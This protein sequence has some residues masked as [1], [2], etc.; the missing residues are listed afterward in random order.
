MELLMSIALVIV[1][2]LF[3][4]WSA[5]RFISAATTVAVHANV[6]PLIVGMVIVGFGTSAP[7][8][9]VSLLATVSNSEGIAFGNVFGSN[10]TNILLGLGL[11]A[12]ITPLRVSRNILRYQLPLLCFVTVVALLFFWNLHFSRMEAMIFLLLFI[13]SMSL[14]AYLESKEPQKEHV[15]VA[16]LR[17]GTI[18]WLILSFI[19]LITSSQFL[20]YGAR[21]IA[22]Y[23]GV[24]ELIIG[25]TV[26]AVGT[27]L[28]E[29]V[30]TAIAV[31]KGENDLAFGNIIGSNIF[32]LLFVLGVAGLVR[33]VP[34][35]RALLYRD[36]VSMFAAVLLLIPFVYRRGQLSRV[37]GILFVALYCLY[38][39]WLIR[40]AVLS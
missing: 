4:I 24:S 6:P 19:I 15:E 39:V 16:T 27:S 30:T 18:L 35:E 5:D 14:S 22:S 17:K 25:L 36:G 1:S 31:K 28:P 9:F 7:E 38:T 3:L 8:F 11:P 13:A 33:P 23:L 12:C 32:N 20:V 26:V 21:M 37:A 10:I 29:I 40:D 2:L 34:L